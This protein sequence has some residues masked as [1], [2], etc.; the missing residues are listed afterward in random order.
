M[1]V[2]KNLILTVFAWFFI[3]S[4]KDWPWKYLLFSADFTVEREITIKYAEFLMPMGRLNVHVLQVV[5][6]EFESSFLRE[7]I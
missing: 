7:E 3:V 6:Y 5:R 2:L 4:V 1:T